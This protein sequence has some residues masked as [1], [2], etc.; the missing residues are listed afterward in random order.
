MESD[1]AGWTRLRRVLEGALDLAPA[2]RAAYV[3]EACAGDLSLE[4]EVQRLLASEAEARARITSPVAGL[5]ASVVDPAGSSPSAGAR[6][7]AYRL[8]RPIGSGGMGTVWEAEQA[9][10]QRRV[11]LKL[12]RFGFHVPR[13]V[14]RFRF[15]AEVLGR[16]QHPGIA[17]VLEAGF[18]G[19]GGGTPFFAMELLEG[20][21][22]LREHALEAKLA[23]RERLQLFQEIC[24]AVHFAHQK[25]VIHRDLKPS[26][27]LVDAQGRTKIIDF[28]VARLASVDAGARPLLT[29]TG[30]LVGTLQYMSPEQ[31][32]GDS[33]ATDV[34]ADVYSLGVVLYELL[35]GRS[36]FELEGRSIHEVARIVSSERPVRPRAVEASFPRELEWILLRAI[37]SDRV[38]RYSTASELS[39]DLQRFLEDRPLQAG[40]PSALYRA[41]KFVRRHA[42]LVTAGLIVLV[43]LL[44]AFVQSQLHAR[45]LARTL[46]KE[47]EALSESRASFQ[48]LERLL[49][50]A[51][52]VESGDPDIRVRDVLDR[53]P[54][55]LEQ[56][57]GQPRLQGK[58]SRSLAEVYNRLGLWPSALPLAERALAIEAEE[59]TPLHLEGEESALETL[60]VTLDSLGRYAEVEALVRPALDRPLSADRRAR[61]SFVLGKA[62]MGLGRYGE[63]ETWMRAARAHYSTVRPEHAEPWFAISLR[64]STLLWARGAHAEALEIADECLQSARREDPAGNRYIAA[65]LSCRASAL[66]GMGDVDGAI[67]AESQALDLDVALYGSDAPSTAVRRMDLAYL[68]GSSGDFA[69][70]AE[71][72][73]EGLA[74][75]ERVYGSDSPRALDARSTLEA[76]RSGRV[77]ERPRGP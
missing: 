30:Q 44:A 68:L 62:L 48:F 47:R 55:A 72:A 49:T 5:T 58:L 2:E 36:P 50:S 65:A 67:E 53:G 69:Q 34:R 38:R 25:G 3:R 73:R 64:L 60:T 29:A 41:R 23:L 24:E 1:R 10:P 77:P 40:P 26:N 43:A 37:E 39:A 12:L 42:L 13:E 8:V 71:L 57:A 21:R 33:Q 14:E 32:S 46:A 27:I 16:L 70:A 35:L 52:P 56:L 4:A 28:G 66:A 75:Y 31:F 76:Y 17:Q 7:G 51:D 11:A 74:I 45:E 19:E 6:V 61:L 54:A 9:S 22:T 63:G 18:H 59:G 15:E 20:A